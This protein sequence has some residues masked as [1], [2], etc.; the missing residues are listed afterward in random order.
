MPQ[1][2]RLASFV[3]GAFCI[4]HLYAQGLSQWKDPSTHST[5]FVTVDKNVQVEVLDWGGL[6]RSIILLAGGGFTAHVFDDFAPKLAA[7]WHVYGIRRRGFGTSG[8][9]ATQTP[10]ERLGE[11]V[12][13]VIDALKMNRPV[14]VGH[15]I[16]DAEM[17]SVAKNHP[18]RIAG[19]VYLDAAYS[20]AFDNGKGANVNEMQ[21]L[22]APNFGGTC[23][24][25]GNWRIVCA[26]PRTDNARTRPQGRVVVR[27]LV[28]PSAP[29]HLDYLGQDGGCRS[30]HSA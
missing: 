10:A 28:I 7:T 14:L 24:E 1:H 17:S 2:S 5:R 19:M 25:D 15:S 18:D 23:D 12:V 30:I 4:G 6:G 26:P 11:D 8:Y 13:A 29:E 9:S 27:E 22:R 3:V 20:Y 21:A 16:A